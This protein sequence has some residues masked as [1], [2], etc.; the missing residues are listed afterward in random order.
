[1]TNQYIDQ[2][3]LTVRQAIFGNVGTLGSFVVSQADANILE[4]EFAP[5]VSSDDMVSL[6]VYSMYVKLCVDG[7]TT[8]P[9]SAKSLAPRYE[10]FGLKED[11]VALSREKYGTPR[12]EIE[13]KINRWS[14]QSYSDSG[15][16]SVTKKDGKG[17]QKN[18]S[19]NKGD[20]KKT[21]SKS[22]KGTGKKKNSS[23]NKPKGNVT[24]KVEPKKEEVLSEQIKEDLKV[25]NDVKPKV[26]KK[27]E[28]KG[29]EEHKY[30]VT[31]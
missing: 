1:M 2:L 30:R 26:E 17:N 18:H 6:D 14:N 19:S 29:R 7:M 12:E 20:D 22:N 27:V 24:K 25:I 13:D 8:V 23:G 4:Q 10:K 5:G 16:R 11:V 28:D 21:D 9:F 3:P 15:N 31:V